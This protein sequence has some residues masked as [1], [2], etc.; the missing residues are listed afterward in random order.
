VEVTLLPCVQ[1]SATAAV[2]LDRARTEDDARWPTAAAREQTEARRTYAAR[3]AVAAAQELAEQAGP[4]GD[5]L[6][7]NSRNGES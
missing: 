1:V 6:F 7:L 2:L 5:C 3:C 4:P